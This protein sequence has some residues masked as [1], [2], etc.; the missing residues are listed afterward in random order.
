MRVD[1]T[2]TRGS[3]K[4]TYPSQLLGLQGPLRATDSPLQSRVRLGGCL[5]LSLSPFHLML[6]WLLVSVTL[7]GKSHQAS[8]SCAHHQHETPSPSKCLWWQAEEREQKNNNNTC[9]TLLGALQEQCLVCHHWLP[10]N[11]K[12]NPEDMSVIFPPTPLPP[13]LLA[14]PTIYWMEIFVH[15]APLSRPIKHRKQ[16]S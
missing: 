15:Q 12:T 13:P 16:L 2:S 10:I 4:K 9:D 11:I 8:S 7:A 1:N 14:P 3:R 5:L 6:C